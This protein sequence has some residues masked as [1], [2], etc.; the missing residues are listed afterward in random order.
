MKKENNIP[1]MVAATGH[2]WEPEGLTKPSSEARKK[3]TY[4][5]EFLVL[6]KSLNLFN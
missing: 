5:P 2:H 4:H 3:G 1:Q 6:Y